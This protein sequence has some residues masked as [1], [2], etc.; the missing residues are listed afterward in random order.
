[1]Q[2]IQKGEEPKELVNWKT[3]YQ[4]RLQ[5]IYNDAT[6][7]GSVVWKFMDTDGRDVL[8]TKSL[9]REILVSE[10]KYLCCYCGQRI[11]LD[12]KT[13]IEHLNSKSVN[14]HLSYDYFNLLA[15]C[16]GSTSDLIYLAKEGD[17]LSSIAK[18]FEVDEEDLEEIWV[19]DFYKKKYGKDLEIENI[20]NGDRVIIILKANKNEYHC[21]PKKDV[22]SINITPLEIDCQSKFSFD[23]ASGKIIE[24]TEN[25][26]TIDVLGLNNNPYLNHRRLKK[27]NAAILLR[28]LIVARFGQD[29]A[30]FSSK[31]EEA[32]TNLQKSD[33]NKLPSF[34]FVTINV[35]TKK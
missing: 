7:T 28:N 32:I 30:L 16:N 26:L 3:K 17:T 14:K 9:L 20:K 4:E 25:R 22:D 2:H 12:T 15:S 21:D 8:C 33:D 19:N 5:A 29:K 1:M 31:L 24:T 27:L 6:I 18:E 13:R 35:L 11:Q 34:V 10:Q 23:L